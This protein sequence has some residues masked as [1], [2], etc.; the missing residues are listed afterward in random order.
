[1]N[2]QVLRKNKNPLHLLCFLFF[3]VLSFTLSFSSNAHI[4]EGLGPVPKAPAPQELSPIGAFNKFLN[5]SRTNPELYQKLKKRNLIWAGFLTLIK[6]G[7]KENVFE[8]ISSLRQSNAASYQLIERQNFSADLLQR[9]RKNPKNTV[10][11][12]QRFLAQLAPLTES[13]GLGHSDKNAFAQ[14]VLS[15]KA[16]ELRYLARVEE[17]TK[18]RSA[19]MQKGIF[20][21]DWI[22]QQALLYDDLRTLI[23]DAMS[24]AEILSTEGTPVIA[25]DNVSVEQ[26]PPPLKKAAAKLKTRESVF[27]V[28]LSLTTQIAILSESSAT[29]DIELKDWVNASSYLELPASHKIRRHISRAYP[30][31]STIYESFVPNLAP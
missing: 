15:E 12:V 22:W 3:I 11:E 19:L 1:M 25:P 24:F 28:L 26:I 31:E 27:E 30:A 20:L 2:C 6:K 13:Y 10:R 8:I 5:A 14:L 23:V 9:F 21:G 4:C 17:F 18:R 16:Q 29:L 7:S